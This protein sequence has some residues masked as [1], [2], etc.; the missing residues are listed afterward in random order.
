MIIATGKSSYSRT[1]E[2]R[3]EPLS[4]VQE[5]S[6]ALPRI[7]PL[8]NWKLRGLPKAV[9]Q[10]STTDLYVPEPPLLRQITWYHNPPLWQCVEYW[11]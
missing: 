10:S 4:V 5:P 9:L 2:Y 11:S 8:R 7:S 6:T 3:D 1:Q